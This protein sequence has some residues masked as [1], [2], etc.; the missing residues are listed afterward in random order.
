MSFVDIT[1]EK[2]PLACINLIA[3]VKNGQT[4]LTPEFCRQILTHSNHPRVIKELLSCIEAAPDKTPYAETLLSMADHRE[5][6][7]P[8][9][10]RLK[11]LAEEVGITSSLQPFAD[12]SRR[13]GVWLNSSHER[14]LV[15]Y[16]SENDGLPNNYEKYH[17][18][19][20][21]ENIEDLYMSSLPRHLDLSTYKNLKHINFHTDLNGTLPP[22]PQSL[23]TLDLSHC[24]NIPENLDLRPFANLKKIELAYVDT[25]GTMPQLPAGIDEIYCYETENLPAHIDLSAYANLKDITL[26][27]RNVRQTVKNLVLPAHLSSKYLYFVEKTIQKNFADP[28]GAANAAALSFTAKRRSR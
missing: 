9:M 26:E 28:A 27:G 2:S 24:S 25:H 15:I 18:V 11:P 13:N 8:I 21:P 22:L 3:P 5:Q 6:P 17:T 4:P 12:S 10:E 7:A 19:F 20:F 23:E 14:Q 16:L 1:D